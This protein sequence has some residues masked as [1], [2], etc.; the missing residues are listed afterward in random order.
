MK[1]LQVTALALCLNA[2]FTNTMSIE[3]EIGCQFNTI[4]SGISFISGVGLTAH[5]L[6]QRKVS[7]KN[8]DD[9][10]KKFDIESQQEHEGHD[11]ESHIHPDTKMPRTVEE[12]KG[13]RRWVIEGTQFELTC[14][15]IPA[16]TCCLT[17]CFMA[18]LAWNDC[19]K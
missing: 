10:M 4:A 12:I 11:N 19:S 7:M 16:V 18:C 5:Y 8:L 3:D 15:T 17:S 2:R 9:S 13:R 6:N 14:D 1:L